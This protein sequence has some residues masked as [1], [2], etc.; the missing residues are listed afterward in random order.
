MRRLKVYFAASVRGAGRDVEA[1]K[2]AIDTI[3]EMGHVPLTAHLARGGEDLS[4][5]EV[6]RRD[7]SLL[8]EADLLIAEVT[9]PSLGVGFEICEAL[10]LKK[11]I[12][13]VARE[14]VKVSKL[15]AGVAEVRRYSTLEGLSEIIRDILTSFT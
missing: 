15:V 10:H 7:M 9:F 6:Y 8:K 13:L 5:E 2:R 1:I 14:G 11:P 3:E 12:F 4:D